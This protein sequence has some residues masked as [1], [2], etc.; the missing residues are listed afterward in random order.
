MVRISRSP[1]CAQGDRFHRLI[2]NRRI[3]QRKLHTIESHQSG[4]GPQRIDSRPE[5]GVSGTPPPP[6][7]HVA[8]ST[9]RENIDRSSGPDSAPTSRLRP[10]PPAAHA[11][12]QMRR[13]GASIRKSFRIFSEPHRATAVSP[14]DEA[15]HWF[16]LCA[17][18]ANSTVLSASASPKWKVPSP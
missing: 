2:A 13:R 17:I 1:F 5:I 14:A 11:S 7:V 15:S 10:D 12:I 18:Q 9:H 4:R 3:H 16:I 6:E 8:Q